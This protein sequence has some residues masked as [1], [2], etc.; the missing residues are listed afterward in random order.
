MRRNNNYLSIS[1]AV[2]WCIVE[3]SIGRDSQNKHIIISMEKGRHH[4]DSVEKT[5]QC[6]KNFFFNNEIIHMNSKQ[7]IEKK[8]IN[9]INNISMDL[10]AM[11]SIQ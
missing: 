10:L 8:K 2:P 9:K 6:T 5:W 11:M 1:I 4:A 7:K 3:A